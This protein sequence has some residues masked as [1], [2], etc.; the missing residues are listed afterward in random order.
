MKVIEQETRNI[1]KRLIT[2]Y[3][4]LKTCFKTLCKLYKVGFEKK[5]ISLKFYVFIN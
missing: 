1:N 4:S 3:K 5:A 2:T